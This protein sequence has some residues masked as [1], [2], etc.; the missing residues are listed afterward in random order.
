MPKRYSCVLLMTDRAGLADAAEAFARERFDVRHASRHARNERKFPQAA[1]AEIARDNVDLL[2]NYLSPM[3][4]PNVV[5]RDVQREAINFHPAPPASGDGTSAT[6][7]PPLCTDCSRRQHRRPTLPVRPAGGG[8][9]RQPVMSERVTTL[10]D[11]GVTRS[12]VRGASTCSSLNL[13]QA[14]S[15][16][17]WR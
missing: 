7:P 3:Y 2:L 8:S 12:A 11:S 4:V 10:F 13:R 15:T 9:R 17:I 5:L 16:W 14:N 1:A 6:P